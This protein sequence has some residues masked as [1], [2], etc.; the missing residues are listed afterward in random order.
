MD[1]KRAGT[2]PTA[3]RVCQLLRTAEEGGCGGRTVGKGRRE[4]E[5]S[6]SAGGGAGRERL[7]GFALRCRDFCFEHSCHFSIIPLFIYIL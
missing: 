3:W 4:G 7:L 6:A 1:P 2:E 5:A